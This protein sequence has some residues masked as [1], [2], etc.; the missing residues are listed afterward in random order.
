MALGSFGDY[1]LDSELL[2]QVHNHRSFCNFALLRF[3]WEVE[4]FARR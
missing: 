2:S 1:V 4:L 3:S